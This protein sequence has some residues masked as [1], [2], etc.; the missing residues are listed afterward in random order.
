MIDSFDK[1]M[2][3][4]SPVTLTSE[5]E[6]QEVLGPRGNP[7]TQLLKEQT[8]MLHIGEHDYDIRDLVWRLMRADAE[9]AMLLNKVET[10]EKR[11]QE[12]ETHRLVQF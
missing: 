12:L 10:L 5:R 9:V 3:M 2:F 1:E 8:I 7:I 6:T 11:V 4:M